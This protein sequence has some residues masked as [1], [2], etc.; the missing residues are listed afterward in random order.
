MIVRDDSEFPTSGCRWCGTER[1]EH[2]QRWAAAAGWHKWAQPTQ[3]QF[4]ARMLARR[5]AKL[6]GRS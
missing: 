6:A 1:H 5:V 2:A 3:E 4:K